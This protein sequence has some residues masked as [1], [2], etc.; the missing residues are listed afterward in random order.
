MS[1]DR[2][3]RLAQPLHVGQPRIGLRALD[4][5]AF[6]Q[7]RQRALQ[8]RVGKRRAC[9]LREVVRLAQA[10]SSPTAGCEAKPAITSAA[11]RTANLS[12]RRAIRPDKCRRHPRSPP[13]SISAPVLTASAILSSAMR[14]ETSGYLTEK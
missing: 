8:A 6:L 3:R 4:L 10:L 9:R 5:E 14:A 2:A 7:V 11:W 1:A 13:T 12:P